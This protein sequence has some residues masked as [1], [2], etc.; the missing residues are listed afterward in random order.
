[1]FNNYVNTEIRAKS[2]SIKMRNPNAALINSIYQKTSAQVKNVLSY[3]S[4]VL[5]TFSLLYLFVDL[6]SLCLSIQLQT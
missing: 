3:G 1:M 6:L 2:C 4:V 5:Y